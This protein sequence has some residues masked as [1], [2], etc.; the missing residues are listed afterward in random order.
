MS[1]NITQVSIPVWNGKNGN[2]KVGRTYYNGS[3][4]GQVAVVDKIVYHW[5]DGTLASTDATFQNPG[6]IASAHYGIEDNNVH[7]YVSVVDTSFNSGIGFINCESIAIEH[8]GSQTNQI[9]DYTYETSAGLTFVIARNFN[10][11]IGSLRSRMHKHNEYINTACPGT[12]DLD[13]IYR[14]VVELSNQGTLASSPPP[15]QVPTTFW[16]QVIATPSLNVRTSPTIGNNI[17]IGKTLY[18][19]NTLE[20]AEGVQGQSIDGNALWYR[21]KVSSD[22]IWSGGTKII[23]NQV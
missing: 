19:G 6:R 14:R 16:V 1:M 5:M 13:R 12:L 8:A 3:R 17:V 18:P 4:V 23:P 15:V 10:W 20:I 9:T 22:Y 21:T 11:D 7:Q 2:Y